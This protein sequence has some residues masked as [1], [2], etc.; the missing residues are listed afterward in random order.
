MALRVF[1]AALAL[2]VPGTHVQGTGDP[3]PFRIG[4]CARTGAESGEAERDFAQGAELAARIRNRR[5]GILGHPLELVP[6]GGADSSRAARTALEQVS[7]VAL[8][9][10]ILPWSSDCSALVRAACERRQLPAAGPSHDPALEAQVLVDGLAGA[11]RCTRIGLLADASPAAK[12]LRAELER[13]LASPCALVFAA[14]L[15]SSA[16]E[17]ARRL[18]ETRPDV[19]VLDAPSEDVAAALA[20][21]L[22]AVRTP[23][24]LGARAAGARAGLG[25]ELLFVH[26]LSPATATPRGEFLAEYRAQSGEPGPGAVEG[27]ELVEYFA[28]AIER[29]GSGAPEEIRAALAS[30]RLVEGP[31]G[32]VDGGATGEISARPALWRWRGGALPH[33]PPALVADEGL[34]DG[35]E[36]APEARLGAD[37]GRLR[38]DAFRLDPGTRWVRVHFGDAEVAT[39]DADLARLGLATGGDSPFVDHLVRE[40]LLARTLSIVSEK[41]LRSPLGRG[42]TGQSLKVSFAAHLP[43]GV[44]EREAWDAQIAG[45]DPKANGRA[46]PDS[47]HCEIFATNWLATVIAHA[48]TPPIGSE[49]LGFLDGTYVFGSD[50]GKDRRS[51]LIR[52]LIQGYAG[53][54]GLTCAHEVGHL[55]GLEHDSGDPTSLMSTDEESGIAPEDA[56]FSDRALEL[57]RRTPGVVE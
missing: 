50:Y 28:V 38:T 49:D 37:F 21:P 18:A 42:I 29:A 32:P 44:E 45:S 14:R 39:I 1:V 46:F 53:S 47:G 33:L 54:L 30:T 17:L 40:E 48:L 55:F 56:R 9:G 31:R 23:L 34:P 36:R 20:G 5:G 19:L 26:G 52:A 41:Y 27:Y 16:K 4:L 43:A 13:R 15:G 22:A 2:G 57:L 3:A 25:R 6:L 51:E 8:S 12:N 7:G 35:N 11:L 10:V 24:V